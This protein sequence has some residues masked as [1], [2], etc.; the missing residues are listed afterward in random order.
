MR[1][2]EAA[3]NDHSARHDSEQSADLL[4]DG[5]LDTLGTILMVMG[6]HA[7]P[8]D[9]E[10]DT[11]E[12]AG[13]C[14]NFARHIENGVAV[15]SHQV[16]PTTNGQRN[17]ASVRRF[18]TDR[19][20][21]EST[22]VTQRIGG[23]RE[24]VDNLVSGLR[25]IGQRD[26]TAQTDIL[27]CLTVIE[28]TVASGSLDDIRAVLART[29]ETVTDTFEAQREE[30]E[31]KLSELNDKI[32]GM[33]QDLVTVREEMKRDALTEAFNRGAFDAAIEQTINSH[34]L[35][36]Q[37]LV[38]LMIDID[39]FKQVN[40][41]WG[42]TAGD[43]ILRTVGETL[44]RSFVR[45]NDFI[46]RYGGDEFAVLLPDTTALHAEKIVER[47]LDAIRKLQFTLGGEDVRITCSVGYAEIDTNDS[48]ESLVERADRALYL[49]KEAGRNCSRFTQ[50]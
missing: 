35:T 39:Q 42:H 46:A 31:R 7:F 37:P 14:G 33:Q 47:Y 13:V 23:Y 2:D 44:A 27:E 9:D 8:M 11:A 34:F 45:R 43:D 1:T 38:L 4:V 25:E 24:I 6:T 40:D 17:W 50:K 48:A 36:R 32:S 22:F 10:L 12:F 5:A 41:T 16:E 21:A 3:A 49:A 28:N 19:R 30:Y 29:V 20:K 26:L 18:Y 15:P